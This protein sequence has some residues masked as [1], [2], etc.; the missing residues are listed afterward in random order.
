V[1]DVVYVRWNAGRAVGRRSGWEHK[2]GAVL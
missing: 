2:K 1:V